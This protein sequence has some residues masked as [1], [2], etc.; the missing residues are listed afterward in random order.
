MNFAK[1]CKELRRKKAATQE[2][3]AAALNIS[4]QAISK[5]ENGQTLPDIMLLPELSVYFGVT[6]DELFDMTDEKHFDRIRNMIELQ[7]TIDEH[8]FEYARKFLITQL[9]EPE[10]AERA[11]ELLS[12]LYNNKAEEYRSK[13]EYY[14]KEALELFPENHDLHANLSEAWQG[15]CGDWNQDKRT[16]RIL[17]YRQFLARH[18]QCEEGWKWFYLQL[19]HEGRYQE[20]EEALKQMEATAT[21]AEKAARLKLYRT[22]LL[23]KSGK[24]EEAL[25]QLEQIIVKFPDSWLIQNISADM[26]A[27]ACLY[28][29]AIA[30]YERAMLVQP[31]PRYTDA[32]MAIAQ[33]CEITGDTERA[34][35]AWKCYIRI[36][37]ED[38]NIVEGAD[39]DR[40]HRKIRELKRTEEL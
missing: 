21:N 24:R 27:E 38:W 29:Q 39:I 4:S 18:P 9:S 31:C 32:A 30:C 16:E 2:Q 1:K 15:V 19:L 20:A 36:L 14:A 11:L 6:I 17:Y 22:R 8:D 13:A 25:K 34:A 28:D 10:A 3:M 12:A 33:I 5:W 7:E 23:W 26:Y 37:N 35:E 40:A